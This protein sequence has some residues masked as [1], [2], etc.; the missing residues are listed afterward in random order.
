MK[1]IDPTSLA[2]DA[3]MLAEPVAESAMVNLKITE[4]DIGERTY[5]FTFNGQDI[6]QVVPNQRPSFVVLDVKENNIRLLTSVFD[7]PEDYYLL[8]ILR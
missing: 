7:F 3:L 6:C 4:S 8:E 2:Q 1:I 5:T